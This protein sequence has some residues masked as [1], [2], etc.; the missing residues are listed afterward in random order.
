MRI[1]GEILRFVKGK[2]IGTHGPVIWDDLLQGGALA[3]FLCDVG[4]TTTLY[5]LTLH[6]LGSPNL[7]LITSVLSLLPSSPATLRFAAYSEPFFT[8]LSYKGKLPLPILLISN[9][10]NGLI[11]DKGMLS[12]AR[13]QWFYA[14]VYFAL[15]GTFRATGVLLGGFILW[16]LIIDPF[17]HRKHVRF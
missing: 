17:L 7:A 10:N 1:A 13:S 12:C 3:A 6:H 5:N 2:W 16:G 11:R 9:D 14:S 15:A 8:Y 4:S